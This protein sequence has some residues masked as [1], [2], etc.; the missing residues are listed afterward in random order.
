VAAGSRGGGRLPAA[1]ILS[2]HPKPAAAATVSPFYSSGKWKLYGDAMS[3]RP[4]RGE[5]FIMACTADGI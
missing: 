5:G 2:G 4:L 3:N 1:S